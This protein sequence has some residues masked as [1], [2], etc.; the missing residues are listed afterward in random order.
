MEE[1]EHK[2]EEISQEIYVKNAVKNR[3]KRKKINLGC[4]LSRQ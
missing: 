1:L 4:P 3:K 2:V